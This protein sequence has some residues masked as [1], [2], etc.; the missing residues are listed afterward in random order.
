MPLAFPS[1]QGLIAPLWRRWP[2]KFNV[3]ALS[4]GAAVPDVVDGVAGA[5]RGHL[6]RWYGH[7][8]MGLFVLC[9]PSGLV[10]TWLASVLGRWLTAQAKANATAPRCF[11][12]LGRRI[13]LLSNLPTRPSRL[14]RIA[15]AGFSVWIGALSHQFFDFISHGNLFWFYPWYENPGFFPSWWHTKW[16]EIPLPGYA[17]PYPAGP[18]LLVWVSLSLLGIVMLFRPWHK[19]RGRE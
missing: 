3:L 12:W 17:H 18:H 4:I 9:L 13:Q 5:F 19:T 2:D 16:F 14:K 8:L 10:L 1:H 6:G 7:S 15:F 11:R